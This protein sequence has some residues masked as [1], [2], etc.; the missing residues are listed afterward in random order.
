MGLSLVIAPSIV[1]VGILILVFGLYRLRSGEISPRLQAFVAEQ[2]DDVRRWIGLFSAQTRELSGSMTSRLILPFLKRI[3]NFF[4]RFTPTNAIENLRQSLYVAGNP[5]GIGPG[6]FLGIRLALVLAGL[7]LA[8]LFLRRDFDRTNILIAI[9]IPL[10]CYILPILWL[11]LLVRSHQNKI[12]KGLP[13]ALDILS[14]CVD[15]G[16]GFDQ[17]LQR[18]SNQWD[19]RIAAE[20]GRVVSEMEMGLSRRE[21]LRNLADRLDIIELSSFVAIIIQS[22]QIGTSIANTLH[23]Q[24]DQMR[25]ERRYRAQEKARTIPI[26]MLF[27]LAF[28]IFPAI[29]AILIGPAIP[30]LLSLFKGY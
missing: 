30:Q 2:D 21:A 1:I 12:R 19:T 23:T 25:E 9:L 17:A 20:F 22:E 6:E 24:A 10:A 28:L 27:P 5:I 4:G 3:G 26:K 13:S 18:V 16:L 15:A 14:V 8:F 29:M 7:L 11:R